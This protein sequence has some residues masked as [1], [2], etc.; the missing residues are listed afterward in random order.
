VADTSLPGPPLPS[1][2]YR[3]YGLQHRHRCGL[4]EHDVLIRL[5]R[6]Q[7]PDLLRPAGYPRRGPELAGED[8]LQP[9]KQIKVSNYAGK[10]V[11]LNI[12]GSWC[13]PCRTEMP[14]LQRVYDRTKDS[15][16]QFL[17]IDVRDDARAAPRAGLRAQRRRHLPLH[18]RPARPV[19]YDPP[20]RSLL[21]LSPQY[22]ALHHPAGPPAPGG[23]RLQRLAAEPAVP[24]GRPA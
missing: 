18:L 15:G 7:N 1:P 22:R 3:R 23:R 9:G 20:G 6:R 19:A 17:G 2:P 4:A 12:W 11:V 8:L 10:V 5:P 21:A 24:A 16:V 13:G 14:E